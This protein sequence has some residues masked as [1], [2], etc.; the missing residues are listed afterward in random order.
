MADE[1]ASPEVQGNAMMALA[2]EIGEH[3]LPHH[4]GVGHI[5]IAVEM[6]TGA[7]GWVSQVTG[8]TVT[9]VLGN[10]VASKRN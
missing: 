5:I 6:K 8:E 10:I 1:S 9:E 2:R 4:A 7:I 3:H